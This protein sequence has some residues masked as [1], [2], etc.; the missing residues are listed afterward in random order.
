MVGKMVLPLAGGSPAVWATC[1]VFFQALL[2]VGYSYAHASISRYG[3]RRQSVFHLV[4]LALPLLAMAACAAL[5]GGAPI[6]AFKSLAPAGGAFT[7]FAVL[8]L[9]TTAI[10]LPFFAVATS[11]P[12][13]QRWF[14]DTNHPDARDPYFLY[15][16]SNLG[17]LIALVGYPA[18]IEPH[19]RL[20]TQGW[21]WAAGYAALVAFTVG[22]GTRLRASPPAAPAPHRPD[23]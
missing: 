4:V 16:A 21:I 5:S 17:S 11:A 18:L 3:A 19:F 23:P 8:L 13:L 15:S 7:F 1:M 22:C 9:L 10:G 14:A 2:L 12:L 20:S 6:H